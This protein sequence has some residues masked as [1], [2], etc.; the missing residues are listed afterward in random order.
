[1]SYGRKL[2][3]EGLGTACLLAIESHRAAW[4]SWRNST[5]LGARRTTAPHRCTRFN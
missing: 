3:A 1:M 4:S 2:P 5:G